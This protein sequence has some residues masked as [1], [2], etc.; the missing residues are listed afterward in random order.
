MQAKIF[1]KDHGKGA[2]ECAT[3]D[4]GLRGITSN[5]KCTDGSPLR[6]H[7]S[8]RFEYYAVGFMLSLRRSPTSDRHRFAHHAHGAHHLFHGGLLSSA[9]PKAFSLLT[10]YTKN[11][12][13]STLF[14]IFSKR[15]IHFVKSIAIFRFF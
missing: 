3:E 8:Y 1:V 10:V 13:L 15:K 4:R 9:L 5:K 7:D 11:P 2:S 6:A 14:C 12:I